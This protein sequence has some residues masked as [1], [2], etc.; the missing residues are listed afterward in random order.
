MP[1]RFLLGSDEN[2]EL[3]DNG[4]D[5]SEEDE[6]VTELLVEIVSSDGFTSSSAEDE[7]VTELLE[8][9]SSDGFTS[10]SAFPLAVSF[11]SDEKCCFSCRRACSARSIR[12][13]LFGA[14]GDNFGISISVI[15]AAPINNAT[16]GLPQRGNPPRAG[17]DIDNVKVS[18]QVTAIGE[19]QQAIAIQK[20]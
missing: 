9:A 4:S 19:K 2:V 11:S 1:S 10:T 17:V 20:P 13:S 14:A 8:I 3:A 18:H 12:P 15:R 6:E 16:M 7:D 5:G